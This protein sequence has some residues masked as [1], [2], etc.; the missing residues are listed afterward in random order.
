MRKI[1]HGC[2]LLAIVSLAL[3]STLHAAEITA[4]QTEFFEKNIRPVLVAE[5]YDCHAGEKQK[6]G[7]RLDDRD[8]LLKGG[9]NG[10]LIIPG[11]ADN[12]LLI[13]SLAHTHA[14]KDMWMPKNG[15]KLDST[16]LQ[17][18]VEWVKMGAPDPR[19]G[20]MT[21]DAKAGSWEQTFELRKKWWS[22]Q[23]ISKIEAKPNVLAQNPVDTFIL[24]K[25]A[26]KGIPVAAEAD[27][28]T[29]LRRLAFALNG[30]PPKAS[31]IDGFLA[32]KSPLAWD[33]MVDH[34]LSLPAF[35]ET[36]ARHWMD[37]MRYA[38]THGSEGDPEIP[39]A[40]RYRDYLIR[41]LNAGI[42]YDKLV[43]EHVA[44]DLI[45]PRWNEELGINEAFSQ[46]TKLQLLG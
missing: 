1:F 36:W 40:W 29:V 6:G 34:Y 31:E 17:H 20:P 13:Q 28:R 11:D 12:S 14:D 25:L 10:A 32:D 4:E 3:M 46:V 8:S 38:D 19:T 26:E 9:D 45:E 15:A 41:S 37:L 5:C 24:A 7:L 22:L 44:G 21:A 23:P 16:M 39:Y 35:G 42:P 18:F 30:L 2:M 27:R 43:R 33:R